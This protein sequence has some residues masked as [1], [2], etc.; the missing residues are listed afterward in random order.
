MDT[1]RVG[2]MQMKAKAVF[3]GDVTGQISLVS[4]LFLGMY[5]K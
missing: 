5:L 1:M 2:G 4:L 3:N